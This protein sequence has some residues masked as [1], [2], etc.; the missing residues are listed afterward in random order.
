[1]ADVDAADFV[2]EQVPMDPLIELLHHR[3][4]FAS[5]YS[6][7]DE[8]ATAKDAILARIRE[9][10]MTPYYEAVKDLI[11]I[12]IPDAELSAMA[13][14]QTTRLAE[15]EEKLKDAQEIAGDQEIREAVVAKVDFYASLGDLQ[16]T[17]K[18]SDE[19]M[20]KTLATGPKIDL[21][22]QR[23][24]L[25]LAFSD[26]ELATKAI[27]EAQKLMK[28]GDWERRNRLKVYEGLYNVFVRNTTKGA[29]LLLD[30]ISTFAATELLSYDQYIFVTAL[31]GLLTLDRAAMKKQLVDSP[32][33]LSAH[34]PEVIELV[35][36]I[37]NCKYGSL[38]DDLAA[39]CHQMRRCVFLV[40]HVNY[41]FRE[42]RI[43]VFNQFLDSYSSVTLA[44]M[45]KSFNIPVSVLDQMLFTLIS[46]QRLSSRIDRVSG[47]VKTYRGNEVNFQYHRIVKEGDVLLNKMQKLSRVVES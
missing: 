35:T 27:A 22:L 34:V 14:W 32:E 1:M 18:L 20:S 8:K 6:T 25:G 24:R 15:L 40:S 45:A 39:V 46:N 11:G 28:E 37:Y 10:K 30:A 5:E 3:F 33:V 17:L 16:T 23:V 26:G 7:P 19:C 43:K 38:F 4:T 44:S 2:E 31:S 41:F 36:N 42:V 29:T 12:T 47:D 9:N 13:A 21:C